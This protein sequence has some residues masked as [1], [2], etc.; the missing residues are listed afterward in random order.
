MDL[1]SYRIPLGVTAGIT[2]FN[3]P[4]MIPLWMFPVSIVCGNTMILKPSERV[5]STTMLLMRLLQTAGLPPGVV[6]VIHGTERSVRF[7]CEHPDI[8]AISF[9][10]SD[11]AGRYIYE[12]GCRHGKRV[13]CNMGAKNHGI[14][15]PDAHRSKT[16]AQLVGAAF[17]AAGQRCMAL[18]TV[19][20]VGDSREWLSELV[21]HAR[22][23][24]V[25]AGT[26]PGTDLGP[27]ISPQAKQRIVDLI[28]SGVQDGAE[29]LLDGR[30]IRVSGY[31]QGNFVGPTILTGVKPNMR[32]YREEIFGPVLL[33]MEV[34]TIDEA[35][36][37]INENPYGN[38]AAVFTSS[39]A[40][41]RKFVHSIQAGNVGVNVPI[42][43]PLPM[44][45]FTGSKG[46]FL[47]DMNFY[48]KTGF[49]FYTQLKTV[50]QL[51]LPE[52]QT[53]STASSTV[54]P[55]MK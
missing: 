9:V 31:E 40:S 48:G 34:N 24:K 46:S 3:F 41:A 38:G 21:E 2:P 42:P 8:R 15:L 19:L 11:S 6:N 36:N 39:G 25:N 50:T 17:G 23:L 5:P 7:L 14:I 10:G 1:F 35:I 32:C 44:F 29:I 18:S 30:N 43:V 53:S 37:I 52:D 26:E 28:D 27:V 54:I 51:W 12:T 22:K 47:G 16:L 45:S 33:C 49:Q 20:F 4:A 55:V 13:Q